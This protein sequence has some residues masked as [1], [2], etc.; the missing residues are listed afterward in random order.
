VRTTVIDPE[1]NSETNDF[2]PGDIWF[3]P[4]GHGHMLECLGNEPCHFILIFDNGYF[5]EFGTFSVTDWLGHVPKALL[6]KNLGVDESQ[7]A[8][9]P[10][11]EVYFARGAA[12]PEEPQAPL[13]G[14]KPPQ[15]THKYRM[16]A[17]PP[18]GVF[19]GGQ[20]WC[21]DS[22]NFPI[23]KT[24]AGVVLDLRPSALRELHWHPNADEWHYVVE[25]KV[26]HDVRVTWPLSHGGLGGGRRGLHSARLRSLDRE[27][28]RGGRTAPHRVQCG[29]VRIDRADAMAR[30]KSKGRLSDEFQPAGEFVR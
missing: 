18:H 10:T 28:R 15:F 23:S 4:R 29:G 30:R 12:P 26:R 17:E 3:F 13:H 7:L 16:L 6:A 5:S 22:T 20:E 9:Y 1:G 11:S 27:Y 2:E 14:W 8:D 24:M 21:V 19:A 25:G